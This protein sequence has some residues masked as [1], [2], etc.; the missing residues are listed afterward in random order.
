M[1]VWGGSDGGGPTYFNTGGRYPSTDSR[2]ATSP[3]NAPDARG[4]HTALWTGSEMI[5]CGGF[6]DSG[7]LNTGERYNRGTDSWAATSTTD[8]PSARGFPWSVWT[9][10]EGSSGVDGTTTIFLIPAGF[11]I[12]AWTLESHHQHD[13]CLQQSI[14]ALDGMDWL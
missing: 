5:V 13:Q 10:S 6:N 8:A 3:T 7:D 12:L 11:T 1:I 14:P 9:G 4:G 2:T